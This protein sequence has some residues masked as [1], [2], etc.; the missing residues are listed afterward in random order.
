MEIGVVLICFLHDCKTRLL[1]IDLERL[2]IK[3]S[4]PAACHLTNWHPGQS[5]VLTTRTIARRPNSRELWPVFVGWGRDVRDNPVD[6]CCRLRSRLIWGNTDAALA[7]QACSRIGSSQRTNSR[8]QPVLQRPGCFLTL[9]KR[10]CFLAIERHS[11]HD[12]VQKG[13]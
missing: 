1:F 4:L 8:Q 6:S 3:R 7:R 11:H 10:L 13:C 2:L 5:P 12:V 9:R